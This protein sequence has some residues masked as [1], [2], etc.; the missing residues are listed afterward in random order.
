MPARAA[1]ARHVSVCCWRNETMRIALS[2]KGN[3]L[4]SPVDPRFGRAEFFIIYDTETG[5]FEAFD[6]KA[7]VDLMQGAGIQSARNVVSQQ[8]EYVITGHSGPN[9]HRTLTAA[10]IGVIVGATGT[11]RE[12]IAKFEAGELEAADEPDVDEH[13]V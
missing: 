7:N 9:A 11:V 12:A 4:D 5:S 6:N 10:G 3:D 1:L 13:W 8:V 2:A